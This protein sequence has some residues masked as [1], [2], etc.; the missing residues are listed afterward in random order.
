MVGHLPRNRPWSRSAAG[1]LLAA[2]AA[3]SVTGCGSGSGAGQSGS[4][5]AITVTPSTVTLAPSSSQQFTT[6]VTGI[7]NTAVSW[8]VD[9]RA[10]GTTAAGTITSSGLYTA[11]AAGG[12]H[13]IGAISAAD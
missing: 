11:P 6:T 1:V 12:S 13:T 3:L 4:N 10:G 8:T 9:G 7:S 2:M 5:A